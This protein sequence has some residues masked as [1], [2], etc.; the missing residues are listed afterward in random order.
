MNSKKCW[1]CGQLADSGEHIFK[2]SDLNRTLGKPPYNEFNQPLISHN[3]TSKKV[4]GPN[5]DLAKFSSNL[6]RV[7]NNTKSQSADFAY[8]QFIKNVEP[9]FFECCKQASIPLSTIYDKNWRESFNELRKY[10]IKHIC[11]RL[12]NEGIEVPKNL[13][14]FLN[15]SALLK[16]AILD[17][18]IR[19]FNKAF[20]EA[21]RSENIPSYYILNIG[22]MRRVKIHQGGKPTTEAFLSWIT[23]GWISVNYIIEKNSNLSTP[24]VLNKEEGNLKVTIS[25]QPL[26]SEFYNEQSLLDKLVYLE[27][28]DRDIDEFKLEQFYWR[29]KQSI[30]NQ[31][32]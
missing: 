7:C 15:G 17:F 31:I 11:C 29:I 6:C 14:D 3:G 22:D 18:E 9:H 27:R 21:V 19:P 26:K 5:S 30:K 12:A 2:K 1:W 28:H 16:D 24:T 32:V 8:D 25:E 10:Y 20:A 4:Q 13:I 23:T